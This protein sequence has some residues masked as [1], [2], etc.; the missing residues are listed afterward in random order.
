VADIIY[1]VNVN[2]SKDLLL[3]SASASGITADMSVAGLRSNTY[4]L[5][6][7]PTSISTAAMTAVGLSFMR[8]LS[9]S[10][11]AT[12]SIGVVSGGSMVPF[13]TLRPGEAAMLRL[14]AGASYQATGSQDCRMRVDIIEG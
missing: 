6:S 10:D 5:S 11:S 3:H 9:S 7:T 8:N 12:C 14:A 1:G 13:A 4:V 2:V